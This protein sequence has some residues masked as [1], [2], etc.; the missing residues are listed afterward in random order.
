MVLG[1]HMS[2]AGGIDSSVDRA[3]DLEMN[4]LQIFSHNVR[5]WS[6]RE[7]TEEEIRQF[8][9]KRENFGVDYAVV[10]TSYLLNLASPKDDLWEKSKKGLIEEIRRAHLLG[11]PAINTHIGAH[12]G[13]GLENGIDRLIAALK[14]VEGTDE[15]EGSEVKILLENTA[16]A[17]TKLGSDFAELGKVLDELNNSDRYGVCIDTC[18]GFAAGYDF[19]TEAGLKETLEEFDHAVGLDRL[20]LIHLN[21]SIGDRGSHKDRHAHIGRGRIGDEGFA[22]VVNN[23]DLRELPFILETPKEELDGKKADRVNLDRVMYLR[24]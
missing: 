14:E 9:K 15:F 13:S 11:I 19:S 23:P 6:T 7:L 24:E 22:A 10:H 20:D 8:K 3:A 5:S 18:H 21:D 16:G 4:A 17:G 2:I 12:T 1:A